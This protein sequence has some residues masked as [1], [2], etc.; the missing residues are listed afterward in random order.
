M[1]DELMGKDRN[2]PPAQRKGSG[3]KYSD[4]SIC[5]HELCGLCPNSLFKNTRSDLGPCEYEVHADHLE[6]ARIQE[7]FNKTSEREKEN[8]GYEKKLFRY[9]DE[10]VRE[11]DRKI[12]RAKDRADKENAPKELLPSDQA[13]LDDLLARRKDA[14][15]RSQSA[16]E[17]GDV[18]LSMLLAQQAEQLKQQHDQLE[19]QL[20]QPERT[21]TVCDVCGVFINSTDND[22]RKLVSS[23]GLFPVF[24]CV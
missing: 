10:L 5:K 3:L 14:L 4:P 20:K 15:D 12:R 16:G 22:Q 1:L 7:E 24:Q 21:M 19:K 23:C 17:E 11:M 18:D 8:Y 9:L 6:W 2:L 13:R